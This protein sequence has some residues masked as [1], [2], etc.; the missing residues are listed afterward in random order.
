M[1]MAGP[2]GPC[3]SNNGGKDYTCHRVPLKNE[4]TGRYAVSPSK[5]VIYYTAGNWPR[6]DIIEGQLT[7]QLKV[8][9]RST[10]TQLPTPPA[11]PPLNQNL[12]IYTA[13]LWK[14][15]DGGNHWKNLIS[16]EGS[17]YFNDIDCID[18]TH[19]IVIAEGFAND[20]SQEP[21][22]RIYTTSDGETFELSH[23]ENATGTESFMTCQ[24][25]S[26]EEHWVGGTEALGSKAAQMFMFHSEDGGKSYVNENNNFTGYSVTDVDFISSEHGYATVLDSTH[27][28]TL[29]EYK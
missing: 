3:I 17:Y 14:S 2:S 27:I 24:M 22:A 15:I 26:T 25:L 10:S 20:G 29:L 7:A 1:I 12:T 9:R 5:D 8:H 4:A 13:E 11:P 28:C 21:G 18:D 19:C 16:E 23:F 6:T